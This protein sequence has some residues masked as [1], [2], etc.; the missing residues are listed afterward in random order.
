MATVTSTVPA[1][2]AT[3]RDRL[4]VRLAGNPATAKVRAYAAPAGD[5][6][7]LEM[8]EL[9]GSDD[10]QAWGALGNRRRTEQYTIRGGIFILQAGAGLADGSE[11]VADAARNRVY[12]ILAV[13][14]DELRT[15]YT[16]QASVY[17]AQL[18]SAN[19]TQG[20]TDN[21]RWA[22]LEIRIDVYTELTS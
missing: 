17:R 4:N 14:E 9:Y 8:V 2:L 13:V 16:M 19:L 18:A 3:L 21:G 6:L 12:A 1:F 5:P 20:M 22:T 10:T 7:P 11:A 15:N